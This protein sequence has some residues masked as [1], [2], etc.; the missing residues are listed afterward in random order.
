[1]Q[2]RRHWPRLHGGAEWTRQS[3]RVLGGFTLVGENPGAGASFFCGQSTPVELRHASDRSHFR[4]GFRGLWSDFRG[5][6]ICG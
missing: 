4:E 1:M 2:N 3:R 5:L 6:W